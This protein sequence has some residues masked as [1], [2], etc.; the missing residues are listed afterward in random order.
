MFSKRFFNISERSRGWPPAAGPELARTRAPDI[1]FVSK[2][3]EIKHSAK[4]IQESASNK[5]LILLRSHYFQV[6][7]TAVTDVSI[8][9]E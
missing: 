5:M 7:H 9:I 8:S 3:A 4:R 1:G 6:S 2:W